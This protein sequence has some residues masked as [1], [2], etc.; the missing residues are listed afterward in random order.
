M[1]F[2]IVK[3]GDQFT[4]DRLLDLDWEPGPGEKWKDAPKA[5]CVV[6]RVTNSTIY[7]GYVSGKRA[8]AYLARSTFVNVFGDQI[9]ALRQAEKS[10]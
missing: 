1:S 5:R 3:Q 7:F 4:H 10:R 6:T 2:L 8:H 9:Y